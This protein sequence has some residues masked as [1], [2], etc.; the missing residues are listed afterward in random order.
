MSG[1][2]TQPVHSGTRIPFPVALDARVSLRRWGWPPGEEMGKDPQEQLRCRD[3]R[4]PSVASTGLGGRSGDKVSWGRPGRG[5]NGTLD[6]S[7]FL[8]RP[9][10]VAA[11]FSHERRHV[12][13][14]C[15][16]QQGVTPGLCAQL[17]ETPSLTLLPMKKAR[18]GRRAGRYR[19][20]E[21]APSG[22]SIVRVWMAQHHLSVRPAGDSGLSCRPHETLSP[23]QP[24]QAARPHMRTFVCVADPYGPQ[25]ITPS[26]ASV[27]TS[28]TQRKTR[29]E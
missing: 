17:G 26:Q 6:S 8:R 19:E 14:V 29:K 1:F 23:V 4:R 10:R 18:P 11:R 28:Q 25:Q 13:G 3:G 15:G 21:A 7:C 20:A 24:M 12:L 22:T 5:G 2:L 9:W 27:P 16:G